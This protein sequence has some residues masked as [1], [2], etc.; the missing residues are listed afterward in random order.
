MANSHPILTELRALSPHRTPALPDLAHAQTI[1][2][3]YQAFLNTHHIRRGHSIPALAQS[4][5]QLAE[6]PHLSPNAALWCAWQLLL[7]EQRGHGP[8]GTQIEGLWHHAFTHQHPDGHLHPLTPDTLLD[9]FV[10]DELTAL[11]A[12]ANLA[13]A[14]NHPEKIAAVRRLVAYH[15]SNTQP[16]N[17]TNEPW[18]LAAFA[19][20]DNTGFAAQQLFD[21]RNH[22][23]HHPNMPA[24]QRDIIILLLTDAMLTLESAPAL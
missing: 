23:N 2:P 4:A 9:G 1:R 10:Y 11:H 22:L 21:T 3:V 13:L 20:F 15:V 12:A 5:M 19:L 16:D 7:A 6:Q 8:D 24:A 18:A 17:T 14:L